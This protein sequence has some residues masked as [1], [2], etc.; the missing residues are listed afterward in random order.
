MTMTNITIQPNAKN[1]L[2]TETYAERD[3][4]V[5]VSEIERERSYEEWRK[6][7]PVHSCNAFSTRSVLLQHV[8]RAR[9]KFITRFISSY[10]VI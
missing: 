6:A 2:T 9:N 8:G 10:N 4:M 3:A 5:K 1:E 7:L